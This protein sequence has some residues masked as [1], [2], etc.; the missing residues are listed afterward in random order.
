[1]NAPVDVAEMLEQAVQGD[2]LS[3]G[4]VQTKQGLDI[5]PLISEDIAD[6]RQ[7]RTFRTW[8]FRGVVGLIAVLIVVFVGWTGFFGWRLLNGSYQADHSPVALFLTPIVVIASLVAVLMLATMRFVFRQSGD[9]KDDEGDGLTVW[10]ALVK[11]LAGILK[12]YVA[13]K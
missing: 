12:E 2:D 11:E 13:K 7:Y 4:S 3:E 8:T 5:S 10:Q 1:M 6:R 9:G